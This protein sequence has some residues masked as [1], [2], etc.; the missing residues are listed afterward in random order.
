MPF[1]IAT[2]PYS[3]PIS[4]AFIICC[5]DKVAGKGCFGAS[6]MLE[7]QLVADCCAAMAA[8]TNIPITVKC[9]IG[10]DRRQMAGIELGEYV[11][12]L[13]EGWN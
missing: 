2:Y 1:I 3:A 8:A 6:L 5:S 13:Q 10:A 9:R 4:A 11:E 7:P 12:R